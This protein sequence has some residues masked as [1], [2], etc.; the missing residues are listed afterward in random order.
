MAVLDQVTDQIT[1]TADRLFDAA[2]SVNKRAHG[3]TKELVARIEDGDYP[4][5]DR[6]NKIDVPFADRFEEVDLPLIDKLP[7]PQEAVDAYFDFVA[8][9]IDVNRTLSN[10]VIG[11]LSETPQPVP[12]PAKKKTTAKTTTTKKITAK[13]ATTK[14][15]SKK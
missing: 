11:L 3:A 4:F 15:T 8:K 7:E 9:G 6:L 10:R 14:K 1:E 2:E 5:A 13:K 12:A